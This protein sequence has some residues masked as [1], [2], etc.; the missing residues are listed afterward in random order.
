[1][2][3]IIDPAQDYP[4]QMMEFLYRYDEKALVVYTDDGQYQA[5]RNL[6]GNEA[7]TCVADE[8]LLHE[9][10]GD[11]SKLAKQMLADWPRQIHSIIPWAEFTTELGAELSELLGI[12]WNPREVIHRFR[13]K[14]DLKEY[15]RCHSTVRINASRIVE[16][17]EQ[18]A[19]FVEQ[20]NAWPLVVKPVAGA[21]SRNVFFAYDLEQLLADCSDVFANEGDAVL[22][23]EYIGGTEYVVNGITDAEHNIL[24]TDVWRYD[25]R[26][27]PQARN[28]Y[29]ETI[30]VNS[31][32]PEFEPLMLYAGTI[33]E[34]LRLRKAP[35]HMELKIDEHGP[36]LIEVGA[37]FAGG[38]QP[39]LASELH[40]RSLFELAACHYVANLPL[41]ADDIHYELYDSLQAR[42]INGIQLEDLPEIHAIYGIEEVEALPS[43]FMFGF[44]RQPGS[45][46]PATRNMY[47][48]SYEVYLLHQDPE[49]IAY[50]AQMIRMLL[51]YE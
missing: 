11:L 25:K 28:I 13:N 21:G 47:G 6:Y 8:Y 36:C 31:Y 17:E 48:K 3:V 51:R 5:F 10:D 12:D 19:Q 26:D 18:A 23:E 4:I 41:R 2:Y 14:F 1:M 39:L 42:L 37:R 40:S 33:I 43:F 30:K 38:N 35:F 45:Y 9:F 27:T 20:I 15:L 49:Q 22:I 32:E 34:A 7:D 44:L 50:D 29:Y 24:V 16:N 46:L